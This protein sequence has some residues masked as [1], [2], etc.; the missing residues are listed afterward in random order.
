MPFLVNPRSSH[1]CAVLLNPYG[2]RPTVVILGGTGA[3]NSFELW[4]L[5]DNSFIEGNIDGPG[6]G[7]VDFSLTAM[8]K[9]QVFM[10]IMFEGYPIF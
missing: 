1:Q 4:D 6:T 10:T 2:D 7:Y 5:W 8:D 9:Y 3:E